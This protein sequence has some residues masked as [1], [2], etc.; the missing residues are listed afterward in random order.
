MNKTVVIGMGNPLRGDDGAG[1][2]VVDAIWAKPIAEVT[3]VSTHQ[4]LP[5]HID[6]FRP[7]AQ[8]IFVDASVVGEAGV[9]SVT[10][11]APATEGPAASHHL[12]PGVL[13]ALGVKIYG[14]MPPATLI[15]ITGDDFGYQEALSAR[16]QRGVETAVCQIRQ[17]AIGQLAGVPTS[18]SGQN[19]PLD[20]ALN[21]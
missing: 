19:I 10:A 15:T 18:L 3:A 5:E 2:A 9:V 7:A 1:W 14:R 21:P 8:V 13:L 20:G 11:V 6:L 17:L 12:H 16:V 4:L